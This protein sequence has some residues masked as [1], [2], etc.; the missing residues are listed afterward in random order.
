MTDKHVIPYRADR[1]EAYFD[2]YCGLMFLG[3]KMPRKNVVLTCSKLRYRMRW[4]TCMWLVLMI[5][6]WAE[7]IWLTGT[8]MLIF[9][10]WVSLTFLFRV[11]AV[12]SIRKNYKL[13]RAGR[14]KEPMEGG[15]LTFDAEGY[16]DETADGSVYHIP[17][18]E[19]H[20]CIMTSRVI[21]LRS[22][23][24]LQIHIPA[25]AESNR[26]VEAA[27]WAFGK[28]DTFRRCVQLEK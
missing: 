18:S 1:S 5:A 15:I 2:A 21:M 11:L 22:K 28:G 4:I 7:Y 6:V 24:G 27:L 25:T 8:F 26:C 3:N 10:I 13:L 12:V 14:E 20:S 19:Y 9:A 16:S 23:K 17:W